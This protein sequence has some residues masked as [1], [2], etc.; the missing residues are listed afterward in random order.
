MSNTALAKAVKLLTKKKQYTVAQNYF[1]R[2]KQL[3]I[4]VNVETTS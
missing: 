4:Y 3:S 1:S 2:E